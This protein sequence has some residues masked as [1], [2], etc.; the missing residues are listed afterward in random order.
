MGDQ[1]I[2]PYSPV[3]FRKSY[4]YHCC[5]RLISLV[6]ADR[7]RPRGRAFESSC[8]YRFYFRFNPTTA[9]VPFQ[10]L[11][12][13]ISLLGP[14]GTRRSAEVESDL[15]DLFKADISRRSLTALCSRCTVSRDCAIPMSCQLRFPNVPRGSPRLSRNRHSMFGFPLSATATV[16]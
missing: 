15:Y 16:P 14:R 11:L 3:M 7:Y 10:R 2:V 12:S 8:G 9:T 13:V 1:R 4:R 5:A 6:I